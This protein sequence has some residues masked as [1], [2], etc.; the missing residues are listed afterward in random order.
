MQI[1]VINCLNYKLICTFE[2]IRFAQKQI[3]K[4]SHIEIEFTMWL[5]SSIDKSKFYKI[6]S[7]LPKSTWSIS[8]LQTFNVYKNGLWIE[9]EIICPNGYITVI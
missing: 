1:C 9:I 6:K 8:N 5:F 2:F 4:F 7:L 3:P